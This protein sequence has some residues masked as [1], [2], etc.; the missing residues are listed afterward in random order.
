MHPVDAK[1]KDH[2]KTRL[3]RL[4]LA[5]VLGCS[6]ALLNGCVAV[7]AGAAGAG[8]VAYSKGDLETNLEASLDRTVAAIEKTIKTFPL[9]KRSDERKVN[10]WKIK[11]D[12]IRNQAVTFTARKLNT[13]NTALSIRVGTWGDETESLRILDAVKK[14]L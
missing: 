9:I 11:A 8:A 6:V 12:T 13:E 7:M 1:D 14:N 4:L 5:V 3:T 10:E 2:M